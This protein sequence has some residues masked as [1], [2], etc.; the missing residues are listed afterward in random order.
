[1][2]THNLFISHS[3][4]YSDHYDRLVELLKER[5]YLS[6]KNH[7]VPKDDPIHHA[8]SEL[9]LKAA[10]KARMTPCGI[11]LILAGVYAS[12]SKWIDIEIDLAQG[13]FMPSKPVIAIVPWGSERTSTVVRNAARRIV[14]WRADSVVGAIRELA[15]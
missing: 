15:S 2:K 7:S 13:R 11:V 1:M 4:S 9:A 12:Y 3:W 14:G 8:R 5:P 6:F 10:I